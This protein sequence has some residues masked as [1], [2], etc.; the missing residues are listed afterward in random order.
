[1]T[2]AD[3][4]LTVTRGLLRL[5]HSGLQQFHPATGAFQS[6]Q[7]DVKASAVLVS[8]TTPDRHGD[9]AD[10]VLTITWSRIRC[11]DP[12]RAGC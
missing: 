3:Q 8:D 6:I 7:A 11:H 2:D 10:A 5:V 1:M 9:A 4:R 12:D